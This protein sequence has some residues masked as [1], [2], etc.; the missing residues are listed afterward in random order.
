MK[1]LNLKEYRLV[2]SLDGWGDHEIIETNCPTLAL[3]ARE[4]W[5]KRG[6]EV[7]LYRVEYRVVE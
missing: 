1:N 4:S 7:V 2:I 5:E 3:D 6:F